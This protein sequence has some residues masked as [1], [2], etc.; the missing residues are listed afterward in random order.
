MRFLKYLL[1]V[2]RSNDEARQQLA[3]LQGVG[4]A[5]AQ[6]A[7]LAAAVEPPPSPAVSS[8]APEPFLAAP[9]AEEFRP[10]HVMSVVGGLLESPPRLDHVQKGEQLG[11]I[12]YLREC[13]ARSDRVLIGWFAPDLYFF[14]QRGFAG[15]AVAFFGLAALATAGFVSVLLLMP[16]TGNGPS[17]PVDGRLA[18]GRDILP[19]DARSTPSNLRNARR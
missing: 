3:R 11:I 13:T 5:P 8:S 10:R 6:P 2:D 1:D 18:Q 19:Q 9:P 12:R 17:G 7:N 14:A 4:V 15:G 16:E